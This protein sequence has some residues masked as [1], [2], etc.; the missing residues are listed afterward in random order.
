MTQAFV[1][2][3]ASYGVARVRTQRLGR[4]DVVRYGAVTVRSRSSVRVCLANDSPSSSNGVFKDRHDDSSSPNG[5]TL[6]RRAE[7]VGK[8]DYFI[9]ESYGGREAESN[10]HVNSVDLNN[11]EGDVTEI[12]ASEAN[13]AELKES[14]GGGTGSVKVNRNSVSRVVAEQ[15]G[16]AK[17]AMPGL[18]YVEEVTGNSLDV[19]DKKKKK[20]KTPSRDMK[21]SVASGNGVSKPAKPAAAKPAKSDVQDLKAAENK[22]ADRRRETATPL[23]EL[24]RKGRGAQLLST[25]RSERSEKF[26]DAV[27]QMNAS[28]SNR[29]KKRGWMR[30]LEI[31]FFFLGVLFSEL[32]MR[33]AKDQRQVE[34]MRRVNSKKLK[35]GLLKLGPTFIKLGQ[36]LSTRVD[37]L[38]PEYIDELNELQ[39][40]VP[41]FDGQEAVGIVESDLGAPVHE[42]FDAFDQTPIAAASLGQVHLAVYQG[43]PVAVKVQRPGLKE[44]F[45]LDLK[46]LRLVAQLLDKFDP[47]T[48]G[49][50]RD[51]VAIF[52]ES[53]KLLYE[54]IDYVREGR[55]ADRFRKNF[56]NTKWVKVP[57]V[58]WDRTSARILTMEYCP[59]IKISQVDELE[60]SGIDRSLLAERSGKSYLSQLF[61]HGFFHC[62]PHPGNISVDA[63]HNGRLIYYDFGMMAEIDPEVKRGLVD[64]IF[65][66]YE[67]SEKEICDAMER[68][69]ILAPN[70]DRIT[71]EK[72]G[73]Y[74]LQSFRQNMET[75]RTGKRSKEEVREELS[76]RLAAI[77]EDLVSVSDD[78]PFR[79]PAT[80]TFVFR[81]FTT[82]E[83]IGKGL[84][85]KYDLTKIAQP[86]LKELID[87]KDGSAF[88]SAAKSI[89]KKLGW[90]KRDLAAVVTQPR[91]VDYIAD[92]IKRIEDGDLRVRARVLESE[93]SAKRSQ[94]VAENLGFGLVAST[95]LNGAIVLSTAAEQF[96]F[97]SKMLWF[98]ALVSGIRV[99]LGFMKIRSLDKKLA[100]FTGKQ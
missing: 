20:K 62:D 84:T 65:S 85:P 76:A 44:L 63:M 91:S 78:Q 12:L 15:A 31:W 86:Y 34:A 68:M 89:R 43:K 9:D 56:E 36:L 71:V 30:T 16:E 4:T 2:G 54:E 70:V 28:W 22:S 53:A 98:F 51:W 59:G 75:E 1:V 45:D 40:K 80:F 66:V 27:M 83:G 90:R 64:L 100:K 33:R 87:L 97:A 10:G 23:V 81:A 29:G 50:S 61:R 57:T 13:G 94:L 5:Y 24:E 19:D 25:M 96:L 39:D 3:G 42:L 58:Y 93:R 60:R 99:M 35:E 52:E 77:G 46:N 67:G 92:V 49:A 32:K 82:L 14:P 88:T 95:L 47:K 17:A 41:G 21:P 26:G 72:I 8:D 38:P 18:E 73:R 6:R 69:G 37:V 74:F 11:K 7:I 79:F 48:D 55:N